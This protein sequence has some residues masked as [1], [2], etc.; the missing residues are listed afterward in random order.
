MGGSKTIV[1]KS[2]PH[3]P[4]KE[5]PE[6]R[7]ERVNSAGSDMRTRIVADKTKFNRKKQKQKD[8]SIINEI[9]NR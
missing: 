6:E 1:I 2:T 9:S 3:N 8:R 5:T 4:I 7:K